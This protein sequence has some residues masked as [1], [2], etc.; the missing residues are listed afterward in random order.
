MT[1]ESEARQQESNAGASKRSKGPVWLGLL[2]LL[3]AIAYVLPGLTGHDPWKQDEA[4][5]FGIIHNML[6]TGDL[7]VPKLA[8]DPFMEKPPVFYITAAGIAKLADGLSSVPLPGALSVPEALKLPP[9]DAAR[10][11]TGLYLLVLFGFTVL[12]GRATWIRHGNNQG[13][14]A[15]ALLVLMGTLGLIQSSHYL[16]TDIALSAGVAMALYGMVIAPRRVVWGGIWLGTGTGL[17]FMSKGLLGPG[18]LGVTALLLPLYRDWRNARYLRVLLVALLAAL[19]WI[20]IWPTL[21]YLRDPALFELWFWDNN[22]GRYLGQYLN[23]EP[24][25]PPATVDFWLRTWPWFTFPAALL[26]ALALFLRLGDSWSSPGVRVALTVSTVGWVVL[27]ASHTARDLYALPLLAPLAVIAAGGVT[28]LPRW[29]ITPA[30]LLTVLLVGLAALSL[31]GLWAFHMLTGQPFQ[32]DLLAQ[33]LPTEFAFVWHPVAFVAAALFSVLWLWVAMRFRP[34]RAAALLT[35]PA[36]IIL[37]WG[38][39]AFL[40][41]PWIDAAKSYRDVF[42]QMQTVLPADFNCIADVVEPETL[43]LRESERG[44]AHYIAGI[45]TEHVAGVDQ[46]QCD[47]LLVEMQLRAHPDGFDPGPDWQKIWEGHRPAD[48][49]DRFILFERQESN[50][51]NPGAVP[52]NGPTPS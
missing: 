20:L 45:T 42:T 19:P 33:Y 26:A 41:L 17:A 13:E 7:V 31:W 16:I 43:R 36:G 21:L 50:A 24:L 47:L 49:R 35:W 28:R 15:I 46:I 12:L 2:T 52:L 25:G 37:L 1:S 48:D 18:I 8:A 4:Y 23:G 22:V 44:M 3:F 14:G 38:L 30:Y 27:F 32:H 9:H 34:P 6:E 29:I 40:H 51:E 11:A 5:S 10:L 39:L